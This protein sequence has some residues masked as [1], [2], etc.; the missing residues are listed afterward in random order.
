[1]YQS[2][3]VVEDVVAAISW[4]KLEH[5]GEV[6]WSLLLINLCPVSYCLTMRPNMIRGYANV[7]VVRQ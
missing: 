2:E 4:H 7:Q 5:L 1:M 3:E 6:H